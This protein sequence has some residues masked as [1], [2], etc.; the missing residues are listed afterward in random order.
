MEVAVMWER[1][2]TRCVLDRV[3]GRLELKLCRGRYTI[4]LTTCRDQQD[5]AVKAQEWLESESKL[6]L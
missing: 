1:G 4:R 5:A 6:S 2:T 3:D